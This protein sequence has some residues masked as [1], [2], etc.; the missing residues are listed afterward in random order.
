MSLIED[1]YSDTVGRIIFPVLSSNCYDAISEFYQIT[2]A[3]PYKIEEHSGKD[4]VVHLV[5]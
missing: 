2:G 1:K 4:C 3:V 5:V